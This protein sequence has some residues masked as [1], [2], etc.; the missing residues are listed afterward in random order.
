[1]TTKRLDFFSQDI[2]PHLVVSMHDVPEAW[3]LVLLDVPGDGTLDDAHTSSLSR[4]RS[5]LRAFLIDRTSDA[6][7][8][9]ETF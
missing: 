2:A 4:R 1:M 5:W 8:G 6:V 7:V 3:S 9:I